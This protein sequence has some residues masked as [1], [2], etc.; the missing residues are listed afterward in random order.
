AAAL[1]TGDAAAYRVPNTNSSWDLNISTGGVTGNY[2][3]QADMLHALGLLQGKAEGDFALYDPMT[4]AE[5]AT[6]LV[7]FLG[8]ETAAEAESC[9]TPF[10]D[11][12]GWAAPYIG[13]LYAQGLTK[14]VSATRYDPDAKVT[15]EQFSLF[16]SRAVCG[17]DSLADTALTKSEREWIDG[18]MGDDGQFWSGNGFVR[19]T[20]M[21]MMT[22]A[23]IMKDAAGYTLAQKLVDTGAFTAEDFAAAAWDILP[24]VYGYDAGGHATCALAGV[25]IAVSAET[26]LRFDTDTAG[27]NLDHLL[28]YRQDGDKVSVCKLDPRTLAAVQ[29]GEIP[30]DGGALREDAYIGTLGTRDYFYVP[31]GALYCLDGEK[32]TEALDKETMQDAQVKLLTEN[33]GADEAGV[34]LTVATA[35]GL[36]AYTAD[37]AEPARIGETG[38]I[39]YQNDLCVVLLQE[40]GESGALSCVDLSMGRMTESYAVTKDAAFAVTGYGGWIYGEDGLFVVNAEYG[41][42][43]GNQIVSAYHLNLLTDLP[44]LGLQTVRWGAGPSDPFILTHDKGSAGASRLVLL[45]EGK[46]TLYTDFAAAQI[47]GV[48][49]AQAMDSIPGVYGRNGRDAGV[50]EYGIIGQNHMFANSYT[51]DTGTLTDEQMG[52]MVVRE[53]ARLDALGFGW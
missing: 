22:R 15:A 38:E 52:A 25:P 45:S 43:D 29:T 20:A 18:Y 5:A 19:M 13:W 17:G 49:F 21:G 8:G 26:G 6:L 27:A 28:A 3:Q 44:V 32:L 30:L 35:D 42:E 31:S 24:P 14:G 16:L 7:R 12:S 50:F 11:V 48:T 39:I 33:S 4:R 34:R 53:Q 9:Q 23:L 37:S 36:V 2:M 1:L 40:N 10:T 51:P 47:Q 46:E 41:Q